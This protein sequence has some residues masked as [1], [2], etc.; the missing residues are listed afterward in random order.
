MIGRTNLERIP[1]KTIN[2]NKILVIDVGN[3]RVVLAL[4][5]KGKIIYKNYFLTKIDNIK[6][7][8]TRIIPELNINGICMASV[9]PR[10]GNEIQSICQKSFSI[11]FVNI[12]SQTDLGLTF[13]VPHPHYLGADLLVNAFAAIHKYGTSCLIFDLGT[14]TTIQLIGK[15]GLFFGYNIIPGLKIGM[16]SLFTNTS[17]LTEFN[18]SPTKDLLGLDTKNAVL[19]G[20]IQSHVFII[21]GFI[22]SIFESYTQIGDITTLVTGGNTSYVL[23][24][25][26]QHV[27]FDPELT[28]EGLHLASTKF[29]VTN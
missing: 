25:L 29:L 9:V 12:T 6:M 20:V 1:P 11:P 19:T 17:L 21:K 14:A 5:E 22:Q 16:Q 18:I 10:V 13:L 24:L 4:F 2:M 28:L 23:E 8:L 15:E 3:T 27:I 26:P 7:E